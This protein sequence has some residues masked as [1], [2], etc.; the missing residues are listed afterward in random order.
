M[1]CGNFPRAGTFFVQDAVKLDLVLGHRGMFSESLFHLGSPQSSDSSSLSDDIGG[2]GH[3]AHMF[4]GFKAAR[5]EL[6]F[7]KLVGE[8]EG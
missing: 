6:L 8:L 5:S 3:G 2:T 4:V 1:S 7:S